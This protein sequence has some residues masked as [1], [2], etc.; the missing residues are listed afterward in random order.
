MRERYD[1]F[2]RESLYQAI[3]N[4]EVTVHPTW[5]DYI[6][7]IWKNKEAHIAPGYYRRPESATAR[8]R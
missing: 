3:Q 4:G 2:S 1:V 8:S 7:I 5:E 6:I